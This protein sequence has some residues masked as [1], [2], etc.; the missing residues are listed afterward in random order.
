MD[1]DDKFSKLKLKNKK[2]LS[3][4]FL[5]RENNLENSQTSSANAFTKFINSIFSKLKG[6][7][8]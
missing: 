4:K 3:S 2:A 7:E 5:Q 6:K 8:D 1:I